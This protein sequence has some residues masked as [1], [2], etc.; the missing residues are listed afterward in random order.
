MRPAPRP[1]H[2]EHVPRNSLTAIHVLNI[3]VPS[4]TY[5]WH[6]H[7]EVELTLI[8]HGR[9]LR[10]VG[11]SIR[12]FESGDLCLVG[13]GTPHCWLS[14]LEPGNPVRAIVLQFPEDVFGADFL[15]LPATQPIAALLRRATRGVFVDGAVRERVVSEM[16]RLTDPNVS[17]LEKLL[18]LLRALATIASASDLTL[19]ALTP[20][21][22]T[23]STRDATRAGKLMRH[24]HDHAAERLTQRQVA[25]FVGMSPGAFSRFFTR[26][27]GKPFVAYVAE[28][29]IAN[30]C[31]LLLEDDMNVSEVAYRVGFNNLANFNRHFLRLKGTTPRAFRR[32]A[33]SIV[34]PD[35][36]A[37]ADL[38]ERD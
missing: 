23:E 5:P 38:D 20:G 1:A 32:I 18:G 9:G 7:P 37:A 19:L 13:S 3:A 35:S 12:E 31:R 21:H 33:R 36:A 29:R 24:I 34:T 6:Y 14:E 25:S 8:V 27:F 4:F 26:T 2:R 22:R 17:D 30:A 10:Y 11:D 15:T 28:V 16:W